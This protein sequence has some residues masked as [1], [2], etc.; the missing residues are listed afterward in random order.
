LAQ[1]VS[2]TVRPS[3]SL[4]SALPAARTHQ[5]G[6]TERL[7]SLRELFHLEVSM[8]ED[9]TM[10]PWSQAPFLL[11]GLQEDVAGP[12]I[13]QTAM[14]TSDTQVA[15]DF[16]EHVVKRYGGTCNKKKTP[17]GRSAS[18]MSDMTVASLSTRANLTIEPCESTCESH[19]GGSSEDTASS[20]GRLNEDSLPELEEPEMLPVQVA[21]SALDSSSSDAAFGLALPS[22]GSS[23]HFQGQCSRCCFFPKGRCRNG[24]DCQFCHYPH[25]RHGRVPKVAAERMREFADRERE[26]VPSPK[27][28]NV[29]GQAAAGIYNNL[30]QNIHQGSLHQSASQMVKQS[31]GL[32]TP[33]CIQR[34][35]AG[36]P[37]GVHIAGAPRLLSPAAVAPPPGVHHLSVVSHH[38]RTGSLRTPAG[39]AQSAGC[40]SAAANLMLLQSSHLP[41]PPPPGPP[42]LPLDIVPQQQVVARQTLQAQARLQQRQ[43]LQQVQQQQ[44]QQLQFQQQEELTVAAAELAAAVQQQQRGGPSLM[45]GGS[46]HKGMG[47]HVVWISTEVDDCDEEEE[48]CPGRCDKPLKVFIPHYECEVRVLDPTMPAK[49]RPP[50]WVF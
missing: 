12:K 45:A 44:L 26:G 23:G 32:P 42:R 50:S 5:A 4:L 21:M 33:K 13:H 14:K 30:L 36:P 25:G 28:N 41:P 16:Q 48:A 7:N 49:K 9:A 29:D 24:T 39:A 37:P 11:L 20:S 6:V 35:F 40:P 17:I 1:A 43:Q 22:A 10:S 8:T 2:S 3:F 15:A 47:Q 27:S 46:F 38:H 18:L 19:C 31:H 34:T